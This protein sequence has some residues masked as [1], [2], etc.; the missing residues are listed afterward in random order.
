[1]VKWV[2]TALAVALAC[3]GA[4]IQRNI[5]RAQQDTFVSPTEGSAGSRFQVV[6]ELGWVLG[7]TV[8][9]SFGFSD[10]PPGPDYAGP[11]Y[12]E[13]P[14]TVLRDGTWSFPVVINDQ[15][16][17]FPL[18]RPGYIVVKA[19]G[20]RQTTLTTV[21]YT[22]GER[23]PVGEPPLSEL[24]FGPPAGG[25]ALAV[26]LAG[27]LFAGGAGLLVG[28]SGAMRPTTRQR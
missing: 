17:P 2:L 3:A 13:Q 6:G 1:V 19:A 20:G 22:V 18:W 25:T 11:F 12:N 7:E 28:L 4:I 10:L 26:A 8:T 15:L 16:V 9:I 24:G 23:R 5:G 27:A 21:V 14:V